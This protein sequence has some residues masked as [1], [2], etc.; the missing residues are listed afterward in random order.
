M[1]KPL[2][3]MTL[4]R[5]FRGTE[6]SRG[7]MALIGCRVKHFGPNLRSLAGAIPVLCGSISLRKRRTGT[8]IVPVVL[9]PM[10]RCAKDHSGCYE[11]QLLFVVYV[12][13]QNDAGDLT[14]EIGIC[15]GWTNLPA[16]KLMLATVGQRV[17]Q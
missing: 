13:Y 10:P 11:R 8:I 1:T 14:D 5:P 3:K 7:M 2:R 17:I 6:A 16:K 4:N 15:T 9:S 12:A